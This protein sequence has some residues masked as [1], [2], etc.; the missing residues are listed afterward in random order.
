MSKDISLKDFVNLKIPNYNK[1]PKWEQNLILKANRI[2]YNLY[3][4]TKNKIYIKEV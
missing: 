2:D 3:L 1:L 4:I